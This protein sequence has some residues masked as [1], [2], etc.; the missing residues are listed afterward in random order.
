MSKRRGI[1]HEEYRLQGLQQ[2]SP[3]IPVCDICLLWFLVFSRS[4]GLPTSLLSLI[5]RSSELESIQVKQDG[6]SGA[7][8]IMKEDDAVDD[9]SCLYVV[10]SGTVIAYHG[11]TKD[12]ASA[13]VESFMRKAFKNVPATSGPLQGT[14]ATNRKS[15]AD[16]KR[17]DEAQGEYG[18]IAA[19]IPHGN[20]FGEESVLRHSPYQT[21][22]EAAHFNAPCSEGNSS[23]RHTILPSGGG[24]VEILRICGREVM[25]SLYHHM[26]GEMY[27]CKGLIYESLGKAQRLRRPRD[28]RSIAIA[29]ETGGA[30]HRIVGYSAIEALSR[31]AELLR[32]SAG[33][34][35]YEEGQMNEPGSAYIIIGGQVGLYSSNVRAVGLDDSKRGEGPDACNDTSSASS[36]APRSKDWVF[37]QVRV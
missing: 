16:T 25:S 33:E 22:E 20:A 23:R 37:E 13:S 7:E 15:H 31:R 18:P 3:A 21:P 11:K 28:L 29:L 19:M 32:V 36:S 5:E 35:I 17:G 27:F 10:M 2:L 9:E 14:S 34:S 1:P 4:Q 26:P 24:A 8:P 30:F 6:D 12:E